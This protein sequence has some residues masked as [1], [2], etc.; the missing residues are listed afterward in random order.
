VDCAPTHFKR[1]QIGRT[2]ANRIH[3]TAI[4][5]A[6]VKLGQDNVIGPYTVISG[7]CRIGDGNW[8]GPH[9][10]IGG[11]PEYLGAAHPAGWDG[12]TGGAGVVIGSRS[13]IREF[14]T[15]NQGVHEATRLGDGCYLMGRSHLGH[16]TAVDD[17]VV[18]ASAV[19]LA[20]HVRV[21]SW[22]NI[23]IGTVVHQRTRIGPGAMVGMGSAVRKDVAP[24]TTTLGNPAR[25]TGVNR[26]GLS[27]RGCEEETIER[28]T[29]CILGRGD[30]PDSAPQ[31]IRA[32]LLHWAKETTAT[33]GEH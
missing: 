25:T 2:M 1:D 9:V 7:P 20:G 32:A 14:V 28:I 19:Q 18:I 22:A 15:I 26:V 16:D 10:S 8:I 31:P 33:T 13:R 12:E 6:D 5:G 4:I 29:D 24:F 11:P 17:E 21:G 27:R 23:G 3:P 30:L